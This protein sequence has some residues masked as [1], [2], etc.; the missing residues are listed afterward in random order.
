MIQ[1][2]LRGG[3]M[4]IAAAPSTTE[5]E[6]TRPLDL[7]TPRG[8]L[9]KSAVGWSRQPLH[10]SN[11]RGHWPRKKRWNYWAVTSDKYLF[12][13]TVA[14]LDYLGVVF[15]YFLDFETRRFIEKT[16]TVPLGRGCDL[17]ETV[18]GDIRFRHDRMSVNLLDAPVGG[19]QIGA[20]AARFGGE[21]LEADIAVTRPVG[22]ETLNVVIPWSRDRFQFTSKQNTL[23][24]A[25]VVRIG[26][27]EYVF[28]EGNS[29]ACLDYG[30]GVWPMSSFW[31]WG[32]GSGLQ[33]GRTVGLNLG[34]GWTDGTGMTENG[35][36]VDGRLTKIGDDLDLDYDPS[37]YLRPWTVRTSGSQRVD[38]RLEPFYERV[39]K[40][41]LKLFKSEVHQVFG[42][43][44]GTVVTETDEAVTIDGL[45]GWVEQHEAR[46]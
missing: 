43:Y 6:L 19:T 38:L 36:C 46:W 40:T 13:A 15:V 37:D 16:I 32:A 17:P 44:S 20:R 29:F 35:I 25:G 10:R 23:P 11:I 22:H 27:A 2:A 3:T 26:D 21:P 33:N 28:E 14:N 9:R 7:C 1:A 45:I 5:P 42:H 8:R 4:V 12:S 34:G 39:A 41:D 30:R 24:A 18:E 31:N